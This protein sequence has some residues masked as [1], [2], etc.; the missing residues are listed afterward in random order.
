MCVKTE[1]HVTCVQWGEKGTTERQLFRIEV[2]RSFPVLVYGS[3]AQ[4][5]RC[6]PRLEHTH[7]SLS[8]CPPLFPD[9]PRAFVTCVES[10]YELVIN[11]FFAPLD[12]CARVHRMAAIC[13]RNGNKVLLTDGATSVAKSSAAEHSRRS[14]HSRW[15]PCA[16]GA[17]CQGS[18]QICN[19]SLGSFC[20]HSYA[21][22]SAPLPLAFCRPSIYVDDL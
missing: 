2:K 14:R 16:T 11:F 5:P 12:A 19:K 10:H 8:L 7:A 22:T 1:T 9:L 3:L 21:R 17:T 18:W 4:C 20:R 15:A 13:R 6:F